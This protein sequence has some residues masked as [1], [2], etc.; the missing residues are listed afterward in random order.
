ME[1]LKEK[2]KIYNELYDFCNNYNDKELEQIQNDLKFL[3]KERRRQQREIAT[4]PLC[5]ARL[6]YIYLESEG[7]HIYYCEPCPF[8]G[9]ECIEEHDKDNFYKWLKRGGQNYDK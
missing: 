9:F 6:T 4:C 3:I 5:G 2:E 8:V 1:N 7:T